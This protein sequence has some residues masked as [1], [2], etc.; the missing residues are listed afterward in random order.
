MPGA[1]LQARPFSS[2]AVQEDE[3][4]TAS[5]QYPPIR[6]PSYKKKLERGLDAKN[7]EIR[8]VKTVEE[9]QLKLN[10]PRYYGFKTFM[11]HE[12]YIPYNCLPLTQHATRTHLIQGKGLPEYYQNVS[13]ENLETISKNVEEAILME[14]DGLRKSYEVKEENLEDEDKANLK[15]SA[16][17]RSL[18]RVLNNSLAQQ[19]PHIADSQVCTNKQLIYT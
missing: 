15:A 10:M 14:V 18:N 17:V 9:K 2:P 11:F 19:Y 12:D 7:I 1:W 16:I 4:Y 6:D 8:N 13:V 5:P 3:E